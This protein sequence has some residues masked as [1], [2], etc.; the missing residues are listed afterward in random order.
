MHGGVT[1]LI[2]SSD[3][4]L[5]PRNIFYFDFSINKTKIKAQ[6]TLNGLG[7]HWVLNLRSLG[8][9]SYSV[10]TNCM[11]L[12]G[13]LMNRLTDP[14]AVSAK[15]SQALPW[16]HSTCLDLARA[17]VQLVGWEKATRIRCGRFMRQPAGGSHRYLVHGPDLIHGH[18]AGDWRK[19]RFLSV[20]VSALREA[21][22]PLIPGSGSETWSFDHWDQW[23]F[24]LL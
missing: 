24:F 16:L 9:R 11:P 23:G 20:C 18:P 15:A 14:D 21:L 17:A 13:L 10:M 12:G 1:S 6:P 3:L 19:K 5:T 7:R 8:S 22:S 2:P 4:V